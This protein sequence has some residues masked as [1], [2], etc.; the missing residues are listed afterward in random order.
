ML[1]L[2]DVITVLF[3]YFECFLAYFQLLEHAV[4]HLTFVSA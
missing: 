2:L 4:L 3:D 1:G